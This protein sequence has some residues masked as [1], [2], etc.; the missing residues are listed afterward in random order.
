MHLVFLVVLGGRLLQVWLSG[1]QRITIGRDTGVIENEEQELNRVCPDKRGCSFYT[2][3]SAVLG[4]PVHSPCSPISIRKG[5]LI[6]SRYASHP[7][8]AVRTLVP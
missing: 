6:A 7:Q 5:L 1:T 8:R 2:A 3:H 4:S